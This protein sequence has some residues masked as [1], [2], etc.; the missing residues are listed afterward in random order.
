MGYDCAWLLGQVCVGN[1][2]VSMTSMQIVF[3]PV[4]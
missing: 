2:G 1:S 3:V 4:G